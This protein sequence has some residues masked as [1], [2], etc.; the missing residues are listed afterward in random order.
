MGPSTTSPKKRSTLGWLRRDIS[1][2]SCQKE[3]QWRSTWKG[4]GRRGAR[5]GGRRGGGASL[6][7]AARQRAEAG[8]G[9]AACRSRE[10]QGSAR[11]SRHAGD[12]LTRLPRQPRATPLC[13]PL[14]PC[15][16][17]RHAGVQVCACACPRALTHLCGLDPLDSH[18]AVDVALRQGHLAEGAL[19]NLGQHGDL[20]QHA[21]GVGEADASAMVKS[22]G[23]SHAHT[24]QGAGSKS[25]AYACACSGPPPL[26]RSR[27]RPTTSPTHP[28]STT[29][30]PGWHRYAAPC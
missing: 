1:S 25:S 13:A 12:K 4:K 17:C 7:R 20:W 28:P 16:P 5:G 3:A 10:W 2:A 8:G 27:S 14:Q 19:A 24:L 30:A 22:R 18:P 26:P 15:Q 9:R 6:G 23:T 29:R 11:K 21:A